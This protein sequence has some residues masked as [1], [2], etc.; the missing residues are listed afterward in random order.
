VLVL[1]AATAGTGIVSSDLFTRMKGHNVATLSRG[2]VERQGAYL[3]DFLSWSIGTLPEPAEMASTDRVAGT[4][5][6]ELHVVHPPPSLM[7]LS[8][9]T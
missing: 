5:V 2:V 1:L 4:S 3:M 8:F 6:H 9:S 7:Y